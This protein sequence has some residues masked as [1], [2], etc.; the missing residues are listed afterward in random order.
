[1]AHGGGLG[2]T[3]WRWCLRRWCRVGEGGGGR[4]R[5]TERGIGGGNNTA[6]AG[7]YESMEVE[8]GLQLA[9]AK[10]FQF[11]FSRP[12]SDGIIQ[13]GTQWLQFTD[14]RGFTWAASRR[15]HD[16]VYSCAGGWQGWPITEF[17]EGPLLSGFPS[18]GLQGMIGRGPRV[19][20]GLQCRPKANSNH[21]RPFFHHAVTTW[22]F[23]QHVQSK[24]KGI[25]HA[26]PS[27]T[28]GSISCEFSF[29]HPLNF[30]LRDVVFREKRTNINSPWKKQHILNTCLWYAQTPYP[31]QK[32]QM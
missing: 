24:K 6:R 20:Q 4:S 22:Y 14:R 21:A 1:M 11:V 10:Q 29:F 30:P 15:C 9:N 2:W 16:D 18:W 3:P 12:M 13:R 23:I 25:R 26:F 8:A 31:N 28:D 32:N 17:G 19:L 27:R 7:L 5:T